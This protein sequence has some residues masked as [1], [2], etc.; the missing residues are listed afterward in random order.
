M[1][2]AGS[3]TARWEYAP[4]W[5]GRLCGQSEPM[6]E[7]AYSPLVPVAAEGIA[8]ADIVGVVVAVV[9]ASTVES[10]AESIV[11]VENTTAS[12]AAG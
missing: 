8:A 10:T 4:T 11:E 7:A 6:P 1:D 5:P 2:S 3:G 12:V 9:V